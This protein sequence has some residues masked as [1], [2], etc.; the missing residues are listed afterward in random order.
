MDYDKL[1]QKIA[2]KL[3]ISSSFVRLLRVLSIGEK[4]PKEGLDNR[5]QKIIDKPVTKRNHSKKYYQELQS[6]VETLS[7]EDWDILLAD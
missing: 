3:N 7:K 2:D 4:I 5:L 6:I 1:H